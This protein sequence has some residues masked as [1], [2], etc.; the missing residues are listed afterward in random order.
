MTKTFA[1]ALV[2]LAA[3]FAWAASSHSVNFSK[4]AVV[5]NTELKPGDYKLEFN[6]DKAVLKRGK[7]ELEAPVTL[8]TGAVKY[9]QTTAC[10]VGEDGKYRLQEIRVGGTNTKILFKEPVGMATGK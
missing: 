7:T 2:L 4:P 3:T 1:I 10:C 8:E 5:G 6:G 9:N